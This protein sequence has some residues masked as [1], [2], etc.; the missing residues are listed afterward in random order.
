MLPRPQKQNLLVTII[1]TL[2]L[3]GERMLANYLTPVQVFPE[4]TE[5]VLEKKTQFKK[6]S[7]QALPPEG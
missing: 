7:R 2:Q 4:L 6:F 3:P 1:T 5:S